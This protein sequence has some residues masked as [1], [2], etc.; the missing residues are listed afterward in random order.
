MNKTAQAMQQPMPDY[1]AIKH[2]QQIAWSAGDYGR[3]GVTLQIS[4]EQLCEAMDLHAGQSVLDVA[5]GNGNVT[6][7]AA[8]RFCKVISTDY[9][10]ALLAHS[11]QRAQAEG[12]AIDYQQAD[13]EALPF[14]DNSFDNVVSTFG[15]MFTPDQTS[16][17]SE[18]IRVC[19]AGG[20]IGLANWTPT[21]F[22][23]QVFK[24]IGQYVSPPPGINSPAAWGTMQFLQQHL[25]PQSSN[26]DM[27]PRQF[28]FRY[29][30]PQHWLDL[31]AT[32]YGPV[33]KAYEV[34]DE[35]TGE[36]LSRDLLGLID[37]FNTAEDG[38]MVVPSEYLEV[39][40]TKKRVSG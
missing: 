4:G 19:R 8:R 6:L 38:T 35:E 31:F 20:K 36:K 25:G 32:Y 39:V 3:V 27:E 23:G 37:Q 40:A 11:E 24:T 33:L 2:K 34:L 9:V 30:S 22:I 21:G 16:A 28:V 17:A 12:L 10:P 5:G 29:Q 15:V 1:A 13:A 26:L 18:L 14:A 7:A